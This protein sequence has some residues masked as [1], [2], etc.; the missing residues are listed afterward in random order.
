MRKINLFLIAL[1]ATTF[2]AYSQK[3]NDEPIE[4]PIIEVNREIPTESPFKSPAKLPMSCSFYPS[5][6]TVYL[7][8]LSD[9]GSS[10]IT[11]TSVSAGTVDDYT[12]N[13]AGIC[14]IPIS[15]SGLIIIDI[16]SG[17]GH[18]YRSIFIA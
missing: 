12:Q 4:E 8:F 5:L 16:Y 10:T 13:G 17:D 3:A 9:L 11:V 7:T 18:H 2:I 15:N 1:F 14:I 6:E